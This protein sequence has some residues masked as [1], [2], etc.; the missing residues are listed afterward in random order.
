MKRVIIGIGLLVLILTGCTVDG[1]VDSLSNGVDEVITGDGYKNVL[2]DGMVDGDGLGLKE[3]RKSN[4]KDSDDSILS[5]IERRI[6][7]D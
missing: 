5:K 7:G 2:P 3:K 6:W 4:Y 1:V